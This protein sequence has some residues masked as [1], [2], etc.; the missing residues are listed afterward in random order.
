MSK[1]SKTRRNISSPVMNDKIYKYILLSAFALFIIL[2][3]TSKLTNEDDYYWHFATGRY[4]VENGSIPSTDVF[5]FSSEGT[6]WLVTEWGWDVMTFL[7]FKYFGY[8]GISILCTLTFMIMYFVYFTLLR[9]FNVSIP[10]IIFFFTLFLFAIFER[11]TPRPHIVT[12]LFFVLLTGILINYKYFKRNN[13]RQ[14]YYIPFI[15][16]FWANMHIGCMIGIA[17][18]GMFI[19]A[20]LFAYLYPKKFS[21]KEL[22]PFKRT[23]L[24]RLGIIF[25]IS[26]LAMLV[27]P[28]GIMTYV[29]AV[30]SQTNSKMLRE[31]VMEWIS[32]FDAKATGRLHNTLYMI[33]L[34]TGIIILYHS[35][36]KKDLFPAVIYTVFAVNSIRAI[37]FTV[38]YLV[39]IPVFLIN[40]FYYILEKLRSEKIRAFLFESN[41]IKIVLT[42][43]LLFL[44]VNIPNNKL[45]HSYLVYARFA[46]IGIDSNFYPAAMFN[47]IRE[48][49]IQNIGERPFN[50]FECGGF[51]L[52]NFPGKKDFFDSRD[53]NDSI[54]NEYQ[55]IYS[56]N[57]GYEK[58]IQGYNFDYSICVV[59][60]IV[61]EP[62]LMKK[63][64]IFYFCKSKE[65]KP[66]F[67]NDRSILFVRNLPKF[68]D[69]I[70]RFE[71]KYVT[72]FNF[73]FQ[74]DIIDKAVK[75]DKETVK[76]EI[77]RKYSE[78]PSNIFLRNIL[79][80]YAVK[81]K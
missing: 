51:F 54:M 15:F 10:V 24:I 57:P 78:E 75:E 34:F 71:Y 12:Y 70:S 3:T 63:N 16:L 67:W 72:P 79:R 44:I 40:S 22:P 17:I 36:K 61:S 42:L 43:I 41:A 74:R 1:K 35:Y 46:G 55:V 81:L 4:I 5:S 77:D 53:L 47:F 65:W 80:F 6:R 28:H 68:Y 32:P 62:D 30:S 39:L 60:D 26:L 76:A 27:N 7:I 25:L 58:K 37:R 18:F 31:A 50:T 13:F 59:P 33:L 23:E 21:T 8:P 64:V 20:E 49:N 73:Y 2:F 14:L 52:W 48:N 29:Y 9:R 66:V 45:Y 56:R 11:L 69:I 38:D 19:I